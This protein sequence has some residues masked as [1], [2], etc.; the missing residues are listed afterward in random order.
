[1]EQTEDHTAK[2][3]ER[4]RPRID[5]AQNEVECGEDERRGRSK[6]EANAAGAESFTLDEELV[7]LEFAA[8]RVVA[9][10]DAYAEEV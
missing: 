3:D 10:D 7:P 9:V 5:E 8:P 6:E 2:A 4:R 1:M